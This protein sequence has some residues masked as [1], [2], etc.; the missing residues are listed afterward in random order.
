MRGPLRVQRLPRRVGSSEEAAE[1]YREAAER[2]RRFGSVVEQAYA[3]LGLGRCG[4]AK[5]LA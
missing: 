1:L 2:W 4:D 3:L 5:A